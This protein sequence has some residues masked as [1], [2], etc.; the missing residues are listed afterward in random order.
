MAR[1]N[2][3]QLERSLSKERAP[4]YVV[5]GDEPL[6]V[7]EAC[8]TIRQYARKLG[9]SERELYHAEAGFKWDDILA[10]ANSLSL[11]AD[12]K[13]IELRV[14]N[15][16]PGDAGAKVLTEYCRAPGEDNLLLVVLPKL[17]KRTQQS[18]WFKALENTG[19]VVA[20]WPINRQLLPRWLGQRLKQAGISTSSEA[21]DILA[22]KVEGNLL[23]A[24]QEIEKL[25]LMGEKV[26]DA[27]LM[28]SAVTDA[29][30]YDVFSLV[31]CALSGNVRDA[32]K[33]L[34]GLRAEGTEAPV[35]LWA[36]TR[37]IRS[38][39]T[40]KDKMQHGE[41]FQMA[42]RAANIWNSR[43]DLIQPAVRR[44]SSADLTDLIRLCAKADRTIKGVEKNDIYT[45]LQNIIMSLA[46]MPLLLENVS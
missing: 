43:F 7:Q 45:I 23:A 4:V 5:S 8:D 29:A 20:V 15:G 30:R 17:D 16:K 35:I 38:L 36:L 13:I 18:Q 2:L 27:K 42:A 11:F 6:L 32:S 24:I 26:I 12:K 14:T 44:L 10:S 37:E 9:F 21:I 28:A 34:R 3:D 33:I 22:A 1:I 46:G 40:L 39:A 19:V 25:K 41:S 31:D